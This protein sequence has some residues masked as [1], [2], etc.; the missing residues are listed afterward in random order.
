M[1][2]VI[3]TYRELLRT[4]V[5]TQFE[6]SNNPFVWYIAEEK[7]AKPAEERIVK[8]EYEKKKKRTGGRE[9]CAVSKRT[10]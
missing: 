8:M 7:K 6:L 5:Y 10:L 1:I 3:Q 2:T 4:T 9:E